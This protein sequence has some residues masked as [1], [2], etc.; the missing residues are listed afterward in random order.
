MTSDTYRTYTETHR[1][2]PLLYKTQY[3]KFE[4][5]IPRKGTVRPQ[6]QFLYVSVSD[7]DRLRTHECGNWD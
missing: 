3:R 6:S 4:K 7:V 1:P 2:S 5:N